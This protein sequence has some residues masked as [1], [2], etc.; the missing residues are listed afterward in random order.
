MDTNMDEFVIHVTGRAEIHRPAER[1]LINVSIASSGL[2]KAAV[3]D[4]V[5]TTAKHVKTL[6]KDLSPKDDTPE[7]RDAAALSHWSKTSLFATSHTVFTREGQQQAQ[8]FGRPRQA[9][10]LQIGDQR[11]QYNASIKI[12]IRFKRF[13]ALGDFG[14]KLSALEH[15]EVNGIVWLLTRATEQSHHSQLRTEAAAD[16]VQKAEDYCKALNCTR[17]RASE[18]RELQIAPAGQNLFGASLHFGVGGPFGSSTANAAAD[19]RDESPIEYRPEKV[20]MAMEVTVKFL[21]RNK[22]G[23]DVQ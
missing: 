11:R 17:L 4:E 18:L 16:A 7:A 9:D 19:R 12:D 20:R 23:A 22:S 15:V 8:V 10:T 3:S 13:E 6:L 2:N 21:A 1:A 5:I 14:T